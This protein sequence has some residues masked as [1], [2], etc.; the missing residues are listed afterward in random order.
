[1]DVEPILD[2]AHAHFV[3]RSIRNASSNS[4]A[5]HP[6]RIATDVMVATIDGR[7]TIAQCSGRVTPYRPFDWRSAQ[8]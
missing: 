4:A 6:D 8:S 3:G 5:G 1:V 7:D 2:R